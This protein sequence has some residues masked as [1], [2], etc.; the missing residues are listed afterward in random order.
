MKEIHITKG[1]VAIVDDAD[2]DLL[3]RYKWY[4]ATTRNKWYAETTLPQR[5]NVRMHSMLLPPI[6]GKRVDHING[7]GLDNRRDNLRLATQRQNNFNRIKCLTV[8]GKSL[9]SKFKGVSWDQK[10]GKWRANINIFRKQKSMGRFDDEYLAARCY[11]LIA[12]QLFGE[13]ACLNFPLA[14][15]P[16]C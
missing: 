1:K 7:D 6:P 3:S 4:A 13:F 5:R 14:T 15:L 9:T 12:Q 11:D 2:Y 10:R 8:M 16:G